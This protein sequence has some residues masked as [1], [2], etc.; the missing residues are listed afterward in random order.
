MSEVSFSEYLLIILSLVA[1]NLFL[2]CVIHRVWGRKLRTKII[3]NGGV[4][5]STSCGEYTLDSARNKLV[6]RL[7]EQKQWSVLDMDSVVS[8]KACRDKSPCSLIELFITGWN[9]WDFAKRYRDIMHTSSICLTLVGGQSVE[10]MKL[11]Q[12]EQREWWQFQ[13]LHD[14]KLSILKVLKLYQPINKVEQEL[15]VRICYEFSA[16]GLVIE[17]ADAL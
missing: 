8:I 5:I 7:R 13:S 11:K 12:I 16:C 4:K 9:I 15:I 3:S 2:T 10:L 17:K 6:Y 14:L 1:I